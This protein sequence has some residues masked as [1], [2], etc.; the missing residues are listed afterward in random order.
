MVW[1]ILYECI[2]IGQGYPY[3]NPSLGDFI[4]SY[5]DMRGFRF[6]LVSSISKAYHQ[7]TVCD[8]FVKI[9]CAEGMAERE[10]RWIWKWIRV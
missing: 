7:S 5:L 4:D 1:L 2:A 10:V 8:D 3:Q 6:S 9:L